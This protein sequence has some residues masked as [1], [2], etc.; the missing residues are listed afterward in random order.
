MDG[1]LTDNAID[2]NYIKRVMISQ[3]K[4]SVLMLN[5]EKIGESCM[6]N[7]CTINDIDFIV[8]EKDISDHFKEYKDKFI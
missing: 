1:F 2:E 7:L 5:S 4:K 3:S 8:S 6:N